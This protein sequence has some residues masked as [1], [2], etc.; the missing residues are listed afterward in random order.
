MT[1]VLN[2]EHLE[3]Q[4]EWSTQTFGPGE[5]TAGCIDHIQEELEE[6]QKAPEDIEEW[7]DVIILAL[8]G[9]W[10]SGHSPQ[11]IL[12]A[13]EAKQTKNEKRKWPDWRTA[14]PNKAIG[15]IDEAT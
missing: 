13:I 11:E 10:R 8:D 7:V 3:R 6:I 5:R 15:H 14:D 9:A 2:A 12:D 4:I 1:F